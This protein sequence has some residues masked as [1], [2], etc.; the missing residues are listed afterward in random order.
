[1][2]IGMHVKKDKIVLSSDTG[3]IIAEINISGFN[4]F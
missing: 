2:P 3:D 1:M 4:Y